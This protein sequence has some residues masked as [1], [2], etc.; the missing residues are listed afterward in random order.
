[1]LLWPFCCSHLL[2]LL[3]PIFFILLIHHPYQNTDMMN[4]P[5]NTFASRLVAATAAAPLTTTTAAANNSNTYGNKPECIPLN[6][7]CIPMPGNDSASSLSWS[8]V[9]WNNGSSSSKSNLLVSS[10]WDSGVRL[11]KVGQSQQQQQQQQPGAEATSMK[12]VQAI[13][14]AMGT[15]LLCYSSFSH[16]LNVE[17]D[18]DSG[19]E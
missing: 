2:L 1:M 5:P 8:P 10:N 15:L 19:S 16:L 4:R 18:N 13:P 9:V 3:L 7:V 12:T 14:Q 6:D 11:W 17:R